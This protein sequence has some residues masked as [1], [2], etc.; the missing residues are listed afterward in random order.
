MA[1]WEFTVSSPYICAHLEI[2]PKQTK[3]NKSQGWPHLGL[4]IQKHRGIDLIGPSYI[5]FF[6][7]FSALA[8]CYVTKMDP[9]SWSTLSSIWLWS[10]W[11]LREMAKVI[12]R[13][14]GLDSTTFSWLTD[15]YN[16]FPSL[17]TLHHL[18]KGRAI[19]ALFSCL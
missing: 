19:L 9:L 3:E 15:C 5:I 17:L 10:S 13:K 7:W 8:K 2:S 4:E 12:Y 1:T 18:K 11:I 14:S 16:T 6:S